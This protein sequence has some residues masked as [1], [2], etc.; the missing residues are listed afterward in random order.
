MYISCYVVYGEYRMCTRS[1]ACRIAIYS[2][3]VHMF[4]LYLQIHQLLQ[5]IECRVWHQVQHHSRRAPR[6]YLLPWYTG[7]VLVVVE[8]VS[9]SLLQT[10]TDTCPGNL[11]SHL[12]Q[13]PK[14]TYHQVQ[15]CKGQHTVKERE[16][17][18]D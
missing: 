3:N 16:M 14:H 6:W 8:S 9:C 11:P 4:A 2:M 18:R 12:H 10:G 17:P 1:T 5:D 7:A 15:G 13:C